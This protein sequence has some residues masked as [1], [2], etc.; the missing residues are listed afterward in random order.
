MRI[1]NGSSTP[2]TSLP[3]ATGA[4]QLITDDGYQRQ[5]FFYF[6]AAQF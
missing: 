4:R 6:H 1:L 2:K 5:V 3:V